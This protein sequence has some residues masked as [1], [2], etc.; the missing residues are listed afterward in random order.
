M[1]THRK[2]IFIYSWQQCS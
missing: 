2:R 1:L